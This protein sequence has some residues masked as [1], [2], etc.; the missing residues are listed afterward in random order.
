MS[1]HYAYLVGA[2]I[3]DAAWLACYIFCKSYRPRMI[4]GTVVSAPFAL[5][6]ILFI[7]QYWTPPSLF[8]LDAT[9][10]V[11]IE[12]S[13]WAGAVGGIASVVGEAILEAKFAARRMQKRERHF[14]PFIVMTILFVILE[15]WHPGK[16][17][18]NMIIAL[19]VGAL[20]V[21]IVRPDLTLL[22]VVG[23]ANFSVLYLI[24]F[25]YFLLLYPNFIHDHYNVPNLLGIYV[26]KVPIEELLFAASGGAVWSVA[27]EYVQGYR[28]APDKRFSLVET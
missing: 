6:S 2:L 13:L 11:G 4:W 7:P 5:T 20:V 27:Y 14:A 3:F 22:M 19:A 17:I 23:A 10:R 1:D 24:L 21:L 26:W 15:Y 18:Y 16:T 25:V 8:N 12:D 28:L 9:M